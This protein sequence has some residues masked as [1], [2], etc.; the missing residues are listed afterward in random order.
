MSESG[1]K[2]FSGARSNSITLATEGREITIMAKVMARN[3]S[4]IDLAAIFSLSLCCEK[5]SG[6][7]IWKMRLDMFHSVGRF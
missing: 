6:E 2:L 1:A 5:F 4:A 3:K 7:C